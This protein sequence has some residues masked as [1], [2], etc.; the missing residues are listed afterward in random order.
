MKSIISRGQKFSH[1]PNVVMLPARD[2]EGKLMPYVEEGRDNCVYFGQA[3][4]R[5]KHEGV[6][7]AIKTVYKWGKEEDAEPVYA[8]PIKLKGHSLTYMAYAENGFTYL[9]MHG[10]CYRR[11][12][13]LSS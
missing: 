10:Q 3:I 9:A 8:T 11:R 6:K 4:P 2:E 12:S 13:K 5:G 1:C 7:D